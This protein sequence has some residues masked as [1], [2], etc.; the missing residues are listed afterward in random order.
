MPREHF[1]ELTWVP[2]KVKEEGTVQGGMRWVG[3]ER[4]GRKGDTCQWY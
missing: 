3:E 4:E 1:M 2:N